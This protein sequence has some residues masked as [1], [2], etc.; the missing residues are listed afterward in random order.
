V[1]TAAVSGWYFAH[2]EARY[3]GLG[4]I[5]R[6]QVDDYARRKGW[7]RAEAERWLGPCLGYEGG[8]ADAGE[9]ALAASRAAGA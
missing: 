9:D 2:P 5:Q 3:F 8:E 6:D 7:D 1:P 4:K